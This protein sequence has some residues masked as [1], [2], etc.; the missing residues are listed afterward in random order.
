MRRLFSCLFPFAFLL[1]C[2]SQTPEHSPTPALYV[3]RFNPPGLIEFSEGLEAIDEIPFSVPPNCGLLNI[4]SPPIGSFLA[5]ELSCPNG[6]TV[7]FLDTNT[8]GLT[9]PVRDSDSHFLAWTVDGNAAYLKIDS[10]G[11]PRVVHVS[12]DGTKQLLSL[13]EFTYDLA[14]SSQVEFTFTLSRGLG[15][16]SELHLTE[17]DGRASR[18][19]YADPTSY[20]SLA[21]FS[22]DGTQIA[23]IKI[24]DTPTPFTIGEL[25]IMNRDGSNP[26]QL[27]EAD[28]GHGYAANW[29]PDGKEIAFVAREN[30]EDERADQSS[31]ALI[32]N[33][34]VVEVASGTL[35]Q[36]T[37]L[38]H[39]RVETPYWS[40][41]GNMLAFN[42]VIN[43]R[44]EVQIADLV[45]GEIRVLIAESTCCAAWLRK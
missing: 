3:Y 28:A 43:D 12:T 37:H 18:L 44:M 22:P 14:T 8:A 16:G 25:W 2:A 31:E 30:G 10:L 24:P 41:R 42:T 20:V 5:I 21:R 6:Q 27:A 40:P 35:T 36:V 32:S 11:S 29:S 33:L 1:S 13:P 7:L 15:Q 17:G 9:Q 39:G 26:R 19:L 38:E 34:Y 45:T 23:F 4:L